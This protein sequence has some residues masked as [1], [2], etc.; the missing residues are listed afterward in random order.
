MLTA[1]Q[2]IFVAIVAALLPFASATADTVGFPTSDPL[3]AFVHEEYALG[4]DYFINGTGDTVLFRCLLPTAEHSFEGIALSERSI[5][6]NRGGDWELF[7]KTADGSFAY[8]GTGR[9][10]DTACLE[11]CQS[12]EYLSTGRCTWRRGWPKQ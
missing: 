9:I 3:R 5:W 6:G 7:R 2:A 4:S 12:R 1:M 11:S 10:A 8:V